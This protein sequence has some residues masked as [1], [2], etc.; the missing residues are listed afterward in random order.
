MVNIVNHQEAIDYWLKADKLVFFCGSGISQFPPTSFPNGK[1]LNQ[2]IYKS[3]ERQ[4]N[5]YGLKE[6]SLADLEILPLEFL[7]EK[8]IDNISDTKHF[9]NLKIYQNIFVILNPTDYIF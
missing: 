8:R 9:N 2:V 1:E 7:L 5:S 4:L 3:L 6:I